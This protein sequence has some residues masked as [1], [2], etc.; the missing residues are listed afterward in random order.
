MLAEAGEVDV[1]P[2]PELS[3]EILSL[4][5]GIIKAKLCTLACF[6]PSAHRDDVPPHAGSL[7]PLLPSQTLGTNMLLGHNTRA[8]VYRA[9]RWTCMELAMGSCV[10]ELCTIFMINSRILN[11]TIPAT[12][13]CN[14]NILDVLNNKMNG[15]K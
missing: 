5:E 2:L 6:L 3:L 4:F 11:M 14:L 10:G 15:N 12:T 13:T 9:P 7:R 1:L 8:N